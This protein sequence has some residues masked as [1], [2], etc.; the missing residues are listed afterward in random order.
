MLLEYLEQM[1]EKNALSDGLKYC[2]GSLQVDLAAIDVPVFVLGSRRDHIVPWR[3]C[4][5]SAQ[6]FQTEVEFVLAEGGHVSAIVHSPGSTHRKFKV[7]DSFNPGLNADS[8][9]EQAETRTGSW[10]SYWQEWLQRHNGEEQRR[11]RF[12][13]ETGLEPIEP[14]PGR[15]VKVS[16]CASAQIDPDSAQ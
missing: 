3:G 7:S 6:L 8:W 4:Y 16:G 14:A 13:G 1:Y 10:W 15:Y 12:P 2:N 11:P 5:R 9:N